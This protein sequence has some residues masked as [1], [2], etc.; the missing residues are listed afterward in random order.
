MP[1]YLDKGASLGTFR[2]PQD[3][4]LSFGDLLRDRPGALHDSQNHAKAQ[5]IM[6]VHNEDL[7]DPFV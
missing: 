3:Y 6:S 2:G 7:Q 1:F 4:R 5:T